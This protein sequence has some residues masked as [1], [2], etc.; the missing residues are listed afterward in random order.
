MWR[1]TADMCIWSCGVGADRHAPGEEFACQ[2]HGLKRGGHIG[3]VCNPTQR[4]KGGLIADQEAFHTKEPDSAPLDLI[5]QL[6][7][8]VRIN[9]H[10]AAT[11]SDRARIR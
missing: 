8:G 6:R 11:A 1:P 2:G 9:E 7:D 3:E 10:F 4:W 5:E